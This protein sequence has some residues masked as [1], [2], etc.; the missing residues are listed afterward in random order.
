MRFLP[1]KLPVEALMAMILFAIWYFRVVQNTLVE[2][3]LSY[4]SPKVFSMVA[5]NISFVG[6]VTQDTVYG[7]STTDF[8][9]HWN[10][11]SITLL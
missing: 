5:A 2:I 3:T 8:S 4:N 1:L 7:C 11:N 9:C 6:I 10:I